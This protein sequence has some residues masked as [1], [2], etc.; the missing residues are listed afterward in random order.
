MR[1]RIRRRRNKYRFGEVKREAIDGGKRR[2]LI[3]IQCE[4]RKASSRLWRKVKSQGTSTLPKKSR[5]GAQGVSSFKSHLDDLN[6]GQM[7]G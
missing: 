3:G 6:D 2:L 5:E 1:A 4:K 7:S